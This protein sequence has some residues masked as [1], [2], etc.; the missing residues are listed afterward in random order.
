MS[1][2]L[3]FI[4]IDGISKTISAWNERNKKSG[5][6]KWR[7][8]TRKRGKAKIKEVMIRLRKNEGRENNEQKH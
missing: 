3:G 8:K 6:V 5:K 4:T 1:S 7:K 2:K